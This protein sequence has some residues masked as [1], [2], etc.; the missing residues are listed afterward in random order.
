MN[1]RHTKAQNGQKAMEIKECKLNMVSRYR[2][3]YF[4]KE[5][6]RRVNYGGRVG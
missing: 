6:G 1:S 3:Y 2:L 4:C 5:S